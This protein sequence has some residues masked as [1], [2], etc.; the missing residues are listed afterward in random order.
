MPSNTKLPSQNL[1]SAY[2]TTP[3]DPEEESGLF[4]PTLA[5]IKE[6]Q[7]LDNSTIPVVNPV[8][9][10]NLDG[11]EKGHSDKASGIE[12]DDEEQFG[13]KKVHVTF[14]EGAFSMI[15]FLIE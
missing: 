6:S 3:R 9:G 8:Q 12:S 14:T 15:T 1:T 11:D 13:I 5:A 10:D 7:I 4:D 2:L